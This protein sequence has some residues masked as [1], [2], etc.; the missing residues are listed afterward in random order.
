M[1]IEWN[2][3]VCRMRFCVRIDIMFDLNCNLTPLVG[4]HPYTDDDDI[5]CICLCDAF[6]LHFS[7]DLDA[8]PLNYLN[9]VSF[10][11]QKIL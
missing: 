4:A 5:D 7:H 1:E 11:K 2:G 6:F 8:T 3:V 10:Q 9:T